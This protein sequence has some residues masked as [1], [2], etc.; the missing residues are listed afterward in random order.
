MERLAGYGLDLSVEELPARLAAPPRGAAEE[1]LRVLDVQ[2]VE[3]YRPPFRA[4]P[5]P[6]PYS[7]AAHALL[8]SVYERAAGGESPPESPA[9]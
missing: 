5:F 9:E 1:A 3:P 4:C 8:L 6:P 2:A 7:A